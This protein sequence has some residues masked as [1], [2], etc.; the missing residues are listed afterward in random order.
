M[1]LPA[2]RARPRGLRGRMA[3]VFGT[4]ALLISG[5]PAGSAFLVARAYLYRQQEQ[6]AARSTGIDAVFVADRLRS[7]T[8]QVPEVLAVVAPQEGGKLLLSR[9]GRWYGSASTAAPSELPTAL[10]TQV[11]TGRTAEV[12]VT[13]SGEP[14]VIS[15]TPLPGGGELF[16]IAPLRDL[17]ETIRILELVLGGGRWS[18]PRAGS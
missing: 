17:Q 7:A 10:V 2:R 6:S 15:G 9:E 14:T 16:R 1:R 4:G 11:R 3:L 18:H 5:S 12:V 13:R 8:V